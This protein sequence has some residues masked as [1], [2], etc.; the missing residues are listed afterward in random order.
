MLRCLHGQCPQ[1]LREILTALEAEKRDESKY[2]K[3]TFVL[4]IYLSSRVATTGIEGHPHSTRG[5]GE[6]HGG[7]FLKHIML[8]TL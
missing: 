4:I 6:G 7:K 8:I 1:A 3:N 2:P 5:R